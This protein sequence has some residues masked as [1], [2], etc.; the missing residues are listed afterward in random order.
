MKSRYLSIGICSIFTFIIANLTGFLF[1][2]SVF[3]RIAFAVS[4][5]GYG[6]FL[7]YPFFG[8]KKV[9]NPKVRQLEYGKDLLSVF[10]VSTVL[11]AFSLASTIHLWWEELYLVW[12]LHFMI[13]FV[14]EAVIFWNGILRVFIYSTEMDSRWMVLCTI[15]GL[16][17]LAHMIAVVNVTRLSKQEVKTEGSWLATD[18]KGKKVSNCAT[19]Y[20][21]LLIHG[22]FWRDAGYWRRIPSVLR[23]HGAWFYYGETQSA[24]KMKDSGQEIADRVMEIVRE[25]GCEKVNIIAHSKGGLDARYAIS[26]CGIAD[27]VATLTTI[28]TPHRGSEAID[29]FL[30]WFPKFL[31]KIAARIY[32]FIMKRKG[33]V[34]PDVL[35]AVYDLTTEACRKFNEE[36]VDVPGIYYQ[37][38][39]SILNEARDGSFPMNLTYWI[40]KKYEGENDGL[41][42]VD[43]FPWG[44]DFTLLGI[45]DKASISHGD[46]IDMT[47]IDYVK[48]D[49]REFF[50]ELLS[51][52]RKKGY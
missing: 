8:L 24:L 48:F 44:D 14:L 18:E 11:S 49:V 16:V 15:C 21:V 7:I 12:I 42:G 37:S 51:D 29:H 9:A 46:M 5:I 26:K 47:K 38:F 50:V 36:V 3:E 28:S 20:P 41:V 35:S 10:V 32:N 6:T 23:N 13:V 34:D 40:V 30:K 19:K 22:V 25:T 2:S 27:H 1:S 33:D 31:Q 39:G 52:L 17:P 43:S 4:L 45:N